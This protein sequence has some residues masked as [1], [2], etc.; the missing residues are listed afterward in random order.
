MISKTSK[1]HIF[2]ENS[3]KLLGQLYHWKGPAKWKEKGLEKGREDVE[4][5]TGHIARKPVFE[6]SDKARHKPVSSATETS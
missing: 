5:Y 2:N 1:V 4:V 6:V 3:L